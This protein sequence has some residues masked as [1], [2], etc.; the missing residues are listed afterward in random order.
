MY[1]VRGVP[2]VPVGQ[3]WGHEAGHGWALPDE[4]PICLDH[5]LAGHG[6]IRV[7]VNIERKQGG[8]DFRHRPCAVSKIHPLDP[9]NAVWPPQ[10]EVGANHRGEVRGIV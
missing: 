2:I 6:T 5:T 7:A 3:L 8:L 10:F 9:A 4:S 1:S